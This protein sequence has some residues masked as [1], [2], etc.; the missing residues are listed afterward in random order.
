L[1]GLFTPHCGQFSPII[2]LGLGLR[3]ISQSLGFFRQGLGSILQVFGFVKHELDWAKAVLLTALEKAE[4]I[5][6]DIEAPVIKNRRLVYI[7]VN[8]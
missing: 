3:I 8:G 7:L 2:G 5:K 4:M 6:A 1:P